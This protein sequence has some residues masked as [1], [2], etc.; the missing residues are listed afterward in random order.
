MTELAQAR[1]ITGEEFFAMGDIGPCE[2]IDGRILPLSPT[3]M[4]HGAIEL[5]LARHLA[6]YVDEH[7]LGWVLGGEVG[8]YTQR[9]P[10][11][12]RG[13]DI[14]FVSK[15]QLPDGMQD[16]FLEIPP[17]LIVEIIS[18]SDRWQD[19][20]EKI[21]EYFNGGARWIWIV[22]PKG[23]QVLIY[24]SPTAITQLSSSDVLR[25]EA[26]LAGFE[27]PVE[28]IFKGVGN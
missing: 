24:S 22:E 25:G 20:R 14:V 1:L 5:R 27:M 7:K 4:K 18:P 15:A 6:N 26:S 3:G 19:V 13:A 8:I 10:D 2:L 21:Q 17:E 28:E 11:R 23:E 9:N 12:I 16:G